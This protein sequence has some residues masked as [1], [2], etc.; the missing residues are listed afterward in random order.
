MLAMLS[1]GFY[2]DAYDVE[3]LEARVERLF[4][5]A[6]SIFLANIAINFGS[7]DLEDFE[8]YPSQLPDLSSESPLILSGRYRGAFPDNLTVTGSLV[9]MGNLSLDLKVQEAEGIPLDKVLAHQ[10]IMM[11][12]A[13]AWFTEDKELEEKIAKMSVQNSI[14]SEYTHM[15]LV[16]TE[17]TKGTPE[18]IKKKKVFLSISINKGQVQSMFKAVC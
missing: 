12:T 15:A 7:L 4:A 18:P 13:Q 5:K 6:S 16:G 8:V 9:D 14:V 10:Q 11:L 17:K 1:R 2:E 3:T